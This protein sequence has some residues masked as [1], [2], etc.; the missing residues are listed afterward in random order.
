[1]AKQIEQP[2]ANFLESEN[3]PDADKAASEDQA[4]AEVTSTR[5][6][7]GLLDLPVELRLMIFRHLLIN[8]S[9]L[10]MILRQ[11]VPVDI[12]R[13]NRLIH[14]E[15]FDVLYRENNF[16]NCFMYPDDTLI[17]FPRV[18]DMIQNTSLN[19]YP[20]SDRSPMWRLLRFMHWF[21]NPSIIRGTLTIDFYFYDVSARLKENIIPLKWFIRALGRFTN[22]RTIE[23]HTSHVGGRDLLFEVLDYLEAALEP[24]LG[25]AENSSRAGNGLQFHPLDHRNHRREPS[26]GDW[27]D[28]LDG[29]RLEW[30]QDVTDV[31]DVELPGQDLMFSNR[32]TGS[33]HKSPV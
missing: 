13:T 26:S 1:M 27:A 30:N 16:V 21:G 11:R 28:S 32:S 19:I 2:V 31:D 33:N 20:S 18:I 8:P 23:V 10:M 15:A 25:C 6:P 12:L 29:I 7:T 5:N 14:R 22:F 17:R 4:V 24:V 9:G 3:K